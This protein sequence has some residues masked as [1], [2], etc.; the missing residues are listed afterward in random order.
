MCLY[1][2]CIFVAR[3]LPAS[4]LGASQVMLRFEAL[5]GSLESA[6]VRVDDVTLRAIVDGLF[7][8]PTWLDFSVQVG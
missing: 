4:L 3:A 6:N 7:V 2:Y 5:G 1:L 8:P